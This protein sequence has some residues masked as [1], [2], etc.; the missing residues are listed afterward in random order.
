M[1]DVHWLEQSGEDIRAQDDWLS[2]SEKSLLESMRFAKRRADWRLGRWT[3]K[4]ALAI[5]L[6]VPDHPRALASIEIRPAKS[7]APE[8]FLA[9]RLAAVSISLSHCSGT[10]ICAVA[11]FGVALGCDLELVESRSDNFVADYLT[12]EE[13]QLVARAAATERPRLITLLW[14]GKESALKALHMGLRLDT[15][16]VTVS[17][18][19]KGEEDT[20]AVLRPPENLRM[21]QPLQVRHGEGQMF[22]GWW[23]HAGTFLRTVVAAPSPSPPT[24][25]DA[26]LHNCCN[27]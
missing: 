18:V 17:P 24:L 8:A 16:S 12:R 22:S 13:Q 27:S 14:S 11:A 15:R 3:A 20:A 26:S 5:Y 19:E 6:D 10:A 23:R 4:R 1:T 7:G 2:L 21:W 25:L 9:N